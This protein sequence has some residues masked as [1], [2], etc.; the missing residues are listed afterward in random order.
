MRAAEAA[1]GRQ[2]R[3][4]A[5]AFSSFSLLLALSG[6]ACYVSELH[7]QVKVAMVDKAGGVSILPVC[8]A[9]SFLLLDQL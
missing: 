8:L 2:R 4:H 9:F 6:S 5:T 7:T 1:A 3:R